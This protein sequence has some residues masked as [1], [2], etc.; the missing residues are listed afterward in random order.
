MPGL[1][2][3]GVGAR[4]WLRGQIFRAL[5][6]A[7]LLAVSFTHTHAATTGFERIE[8]ALQAFASHEL[9]MLAFVSGI[10]LF[11]AISAI[12]YARL[13][14]RSNL[15]LAAAK[16]QIAS[17]R[18]EADLALALMQTDPQV[19]AVWRDQ[20][21]EPVIIGDAAEITGHTAAR[22]V[23]V[24]G[25]WLDAGRAHAMDVALDALRKRGESFS[26]LLVSTRARHIEAEGRPVAGAA[27]LRLRDITGARL[28]HAALAEQHR[29]LASEVTGLRKLLDAL[30][31]PIWIRGANG[32]LAYANR[33]YA[34]AVDAGDASEAIARGAELLDRNA[35]EEAAGLRVAGSNF[36]KRMALVAAGQRRVFDILEVG[37]ID[38]AA[39]IGIDVTESER[40]R[41]ELNR[42]VSGH[43]R[44]LDQLATAVAIFG[45]DER[46]VFH[47][48]AYATLFSLNAAFLDERPTDSAILDR[49][50]GERLLPE[51]ADFRSWKKNL[52]EAYRATEIKEH[53][54]HL[55][56]GRTLRVVTAPNPEGGVTY[57]FDELTEKYDL[58][59]RHNALIQIQ[60]ETLDA[61]AEAVAVFGSDGKLK[62]FNRSFAEQWTLPQEQLS[63]RPHIETIGNLCKPYLEA[64]DA[65]WT[66]IQLAVTGIGQ[67]NPVVRKLELKDGRVLDG[68]A[69]PL[70]D[71][72]TL[73][74]FR[75]ISDRARVERALIERNEA[76]VAADALKNT[77]VSHVSYELRSPLTTII[78]FAQFLDDPVIGPLNEK[79]REYLAH[80]TD[81]SSALLA[82]INDILDLATIDA[83]AM[84]LDLGE[85][86]ASAVVDAAAEGVRM[87]LNERGLRL[88]I[89]V[90][91]N[92]GSFIADE[93]RVR[94]VLFNLLSN[95][96]GFSPEGAEVKISA[97]RTE[98]A[99]RFTIS[100]NG[101]GI[102][103]EL[104]DRAFERFET[105]R[106][107]SQHR[108]AGLGLSIV[109]SLMEL[110]GGTVAIDSEPGKGTVAVCAFPIHAELGSKA[111][112]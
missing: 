87:R 100:D 41:T 12:A 89:R 6:A 44:T 64:S 75:D 49:L 25:S 43:R 35:R 4:A 98:R 54:W 106:G 23:L 74:T 29:A 7:A 61:L 11:A 42:V 82:I 8:A 96:A 30:P 47:N 103:A 80:I 13:R 37:S 40:M 38:G 60:G 28:D 26:M 3:S 72:G 104:K 91:K 33:A 50:R 79:Q 16:Q 77:F 107:A 99:V 88:N 105:H 93:K 63:E 59:S 84:T 71:G 48:D 46:L 70:P 78:G 27:V 110:H 39:G 5:T 76:L 65:A 112:E 101:P 14:T 95:A 17:I 83:G 67:R 109:Q 86:D 56:G 36:S 22:R 15:E 10:F 2:G 51:Q 45:A 1:S 111:A 102:P 81:S 68:G 66:A 53:A 85:V 19:I 9:A 73:V 94:Q 55:P 20:R 31:T 90:P 34:S 58:E 18:E 108:G 97:E 32:N 57:L 52:H 21:S 62:L 92:I 69:M 24:F